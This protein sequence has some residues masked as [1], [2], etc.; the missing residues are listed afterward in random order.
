MV[1]HSSIRRD[2][3]RRDFTI[4]SMAIAVDAATFG[5]L[6]DPFGGRADL[7]AGALRVLH[8]LSFIEDPTRMFRAVRYE[9]RYGFAMEPHTLE[10]ARNTVAMGLVG[11]VSG[12]RLRDE[13]VAILAAPAHRRR[14]RGCISWPRPRPS[15]GARLLPE[16]IHLM[17]RI[18]ALRIKHQP[19]LAPWRARF[20]AVARSVAGDELEPWL[21]WL[22]IR[23]RDARTIA[24]AAALPPR[25]LAPLERPRP[26]PTSPNCWR[27]NLSRSRS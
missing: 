23:R 14:W 3:H 12:A 19:E 20:A 24:L 7:E 1:E 13:L 10:L 11:E 15:P 25:L 18:D 8:N 22:R 27:P 9:T 16:T 17:G 26:R 6:L 4:N 2:L 21:E 5:L